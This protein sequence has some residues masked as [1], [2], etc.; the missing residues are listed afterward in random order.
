M[1]VN[2]LEFPFAGFLCGPTRPAPGTLEMLL[3]ILSTDV[4]S[5]PT[6]PFEHVWFRCQEKSMSMLS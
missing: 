4:V 5:D 3:G 6:I 2:F 1:T